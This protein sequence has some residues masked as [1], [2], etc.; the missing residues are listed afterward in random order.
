MIVTSSD[1][2][3]KLENNIDMVV[4]AFNI[5]GDEYGN[6]LKDMNTRHDLLGFIF[7]PLRRLAVSRKMTHLFFKHNIF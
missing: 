4:S 5:Y 3:S 7:K 2:K 1:E 6:E